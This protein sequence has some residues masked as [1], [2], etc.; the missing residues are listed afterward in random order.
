MGASQDSPEK[1]SNSI[2][3]RRWLSTAEAAEYLGCSVF[4]LNRNRQLAG[5]AIPFTRLGRCV[6]YDIHDLDAY[7]ETR[8][9]GNVEWEE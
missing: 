2:T 4:F 1:T 6:R 9:V 5:R 7:L 3:S 8:K